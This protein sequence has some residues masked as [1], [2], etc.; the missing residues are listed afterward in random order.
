VFTLA[1]LFCS[2]RKRRRP[3]AARPGGSRGRDGGDHP[4]L[5]SAVIT[6]L[7][8]D[9][10]SCSCMTSTEAHPSSWEACG[11]YRPSLGPGLAARVVHD[12]ELIRREGASTIYLYGAGSNADKKV[13]RCAIFFERGR[14]H[15]YSVKAASVRQRRR[16]PKALQNSARTSPGKTV[17]SPRAYGALFAGPTRTNLGTG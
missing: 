11:D 10:R 3:G 7:V 8:A 2:L 15:F 17:S 16:E 4:R 6:D 9:F 1:A 13:S 12:E 5:M 14:A